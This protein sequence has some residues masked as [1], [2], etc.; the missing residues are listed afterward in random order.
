MYLTG[1][2]VHVPD[3]R[4]SNIFS[5]S[6]AHPCFFLHEVSDVLNIHPIYCLS[7]CFHHEVC[8]TSVKFALS[9]FMSLV[10]SP[11][12]PF[13]SFIYPSLTLTFAASFPHPSCDF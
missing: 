5:S 12:L 6:R 10:P 8:G 3:V 4:W 7:L 1:L 2:N 11:Y 13:G 9:I